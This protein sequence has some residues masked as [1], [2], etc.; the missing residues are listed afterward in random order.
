VMNKPP[1]KLSEHVIT[2]GLLARAYLWLG[3]WQSLAAMVAFYFLYWTNG[4]AGQW[5]DLPSSGTLYRAATAMTLAAI[6]TT[7]IGNLFAHRTESTSIFRRGLGGNRLVWL[8]IVSELVVVGLIIYVPFLQD[9][10]GTASLAPQNWLLLLAFTPLLLL[11]DEL[12][13]FL[14]RREG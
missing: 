12:R 1:R 9:M 4:Y 3:L 11:A 13:K 5:L 2:K 10:F 14:V 8:G 7:Q 6:V